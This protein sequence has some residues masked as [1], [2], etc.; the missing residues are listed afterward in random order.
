MQ[1][2]LL[3]LTHINWPITILPG[4][5][6]GLILIPMITNGTIQVGMHHGLPT[7]LKHGVRAGQVTW[8]K[9]FMF[10]QKRFAARKAIFPILF[11]PIGTIAT[12][13]LLLLQ[14]MEHQYRMVVS[15]P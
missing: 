12:L 14:L 11:Q 4:L 3:H 10:G 15:L 1:D 9:R 5:T 7:T 6:Q 13:S 8:V 2:L